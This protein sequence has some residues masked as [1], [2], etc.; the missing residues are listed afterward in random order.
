MA[1]F[2]ALIKFILYRVYIFLGS[3]AQ[4]LLLHQQVTVL[5]LVLILGAEDLRN[6]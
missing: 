2:I 5:T 4:V 6:L 1:V 3:G